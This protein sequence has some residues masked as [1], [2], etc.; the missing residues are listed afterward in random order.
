MGR[1]RMEGVEVEREVRV[2]FTQCLYMIISEL[3]VCALRIWLASVLAL[4]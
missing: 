1:F 2:L 4:D 3:Y